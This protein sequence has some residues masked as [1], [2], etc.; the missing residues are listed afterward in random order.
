METKRA[1]RLAGLIPFLASVFIFYCVNISSRGFFLP[2]VNKT[3]SSTGFYRADIDGMRALAVCLVIAAHQH[4]PHLGGGFVGVD[5][6]FVISGYLISAIL[7]R[8][9]G[10]STFS[11]VEFYERRVRRI[12]PAL[13]VV[14]LV[15]VELEVS[16]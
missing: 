3:H 4:L 12:I 1:E 15:P 8:Q 7:V 16:K 13:F 9:L 6:F 11:I 5:V 14:L 10:R 2:N